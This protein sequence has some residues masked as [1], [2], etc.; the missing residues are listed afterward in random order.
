MDALPPLECDFKEFNIHDW[1]V[2]M[3]HEH[4]LPT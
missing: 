2:G 3:K 1:A 4:L